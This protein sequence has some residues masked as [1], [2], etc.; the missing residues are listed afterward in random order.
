M[1]RAF[2]VA[3]LS[4][5]AAVGAPVDALDLVSVRSPIFARIAPDGG[6]VLTVIV[7]PDAQRRDEVQAIWLVPSDGGAPRRLID[8]GGNP[9]WSPQGESI[10]YL[11]A[12]EQGRQLWIATVDGK[13]RKRLTSF[14]GGVDDHAWSPGGESLAI[15]AGQR[16]QPRQIYVVNAESGASQQVT[17]LR[18]ALVVAPWD[19]EGNLSWSPDGTRIAFATKPA[20]R[21]DDDYRSD[22]FVVDIK[23]RETRRI[24]TRDGMDLR[25]VWSPDGRWIAFRTSFGRIDRYANHGLAIVSPDGQTLRDVG[26]GMEYGFLDGPTWYDWSQDSST[27]YF[28]ALHRSAIHIHALQLTTGRITPVTTGNAAHVR[29]QLARAPGVLAYLRSD[30]GTPWDIYTRKIAGTGTIRLTRLNPKLERKN[31]YETVRWKASDGLEVEGLL[32]LPATPSPAPVPV[33]VYLHGGPEGMMFHAWEPEVPIPAVERIVAPPHYF[34]DRGWAVFYPNFRGSGGYGERVR[35]AAMT[36]WSGGF[37]D[38]VMSG[39]DVLIKRGIADPNRLFLTGSWRSGSTKVL[40]L[41]SQTTRFRAAAS[42]SAYPNIEELARARDDFHLQHHALFGGSPDEVPAEWK[43]H[44]PIHHIQNITTPLLVVHDENDF[45][46]RSR[47]ALEVH[48]ALLE[49]GVAGQL[50]LYRS[51]NLRDEAGLIDRTFA[52]F[53]SFL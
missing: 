13:S 12:Q 30:P 52:W 22:L 53:A 4:A 32:A 39:V 16:D 18:S 28:S 21:F 25:P 11:S 7:E 36:N 42:F 24:T 43:K 26:E 34:T 49:R 3:S 46:I 37:A 10:S 45:A 9:R 8:G 29:P 35:R 23:S 27:L 14:A 5:V 47:Q 51:R 6:D 44:S 19:P 48:R 41:L 1:I 15:I 20:P 33:V 40:S 50:L 31:V 38:D 17:D 2:L